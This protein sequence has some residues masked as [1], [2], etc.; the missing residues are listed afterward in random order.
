MTFNLELDK[1]S[2]VMLMQSLTMSYREA[3]AANM[4]LSIPEIQTTAYYVSIFNTLREE[5]MKLDQK[6]DVPEW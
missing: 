3:V 4:E 5:L 1:S 6:L 2:A